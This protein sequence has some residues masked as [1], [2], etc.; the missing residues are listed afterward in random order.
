MVREIWANARKLPVWAKAVLFVLSP[1]SVAWDLEL[2]WLVGPS[3]GFF[4]WW[5]LIIYVFTLCLGPGWPLALSM[6]SL[7]YQYHMLPAWLF[8][9]FFIFAYWCIGVWSTTPTAGRGSEVGK[10]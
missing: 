9:V 8:L 3:H 2:E 10:E 5:K 7:T 4:P 6:S 1:L